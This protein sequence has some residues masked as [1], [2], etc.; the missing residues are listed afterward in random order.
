[1]LYT[2]KF[3][4][5]LNSLNYSFTVFNVR[6]V[7]LHPRVEDVWQTKFP[8]KNIR[9]YSYAFINCIFLV[10]IAPHLLQVVYRI[11]LFLVFLYM[12]NEIIFCERSLEENRFEDT[13]IFLMIF[14]Y[15]A[16]DGFSVIFRDIF[17]LIFVLCLIIEPITF[18]YA[19]IF[20]NYPF[21]LI[22]RRTFFWLFFF[23]YFWID[24]RYGVELCDWCCLL[25][26]LCECNFCGEYGIEGESLMK[27][28]FVVV[29]LLLE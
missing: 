19:P 22:L 11:Y 13:G 28:F 5:I 3:K 2:R 6:W 23:F 29:D 15:E 20:S 7:V 1:M 24:S 27:L 25:V 10:T 16:K 14:L 18:S 17:S 21:L 26:V 12:G 4:W 8:H 9:Q